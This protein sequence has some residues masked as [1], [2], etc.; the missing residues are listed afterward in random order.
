MGQLPK[1]NIETEDINE[2]LQAS[3]HLKEKNFWD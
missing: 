2:T 3:V 1:F